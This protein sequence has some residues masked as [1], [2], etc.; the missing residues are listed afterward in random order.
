MNNNHQKKDNSWI[1]LIVILVGTVIYAKSCNGNS[2]GQTYP[3]DNFPQEQSDLEQ[4]YAEGQTEVALARSDPCLQD[5]MY[6]VPDEYS[7]C[8]KTPENNE[9]ISPPKSNTETECKNGCDFHKSGCDIKGNISLEGEK[10]FHIPGGEFYDA[11][12]IKP[13]YGERWFCTQAE[14]IASGWRKSY[15]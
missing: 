15:K 1:W 13:E 7:H 10:I 6:D 3:W 12:I 2:L 8:N 14:A 4:E 9:T 5:I 11:T